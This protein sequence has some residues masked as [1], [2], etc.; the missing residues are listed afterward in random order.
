M[1]PGQALGR[2]VLSQTAVCHMAPL[3]SCLR[4]DFQLL[5]PATV[6]IAGP[7]VC[8]SNPSL[9]E[10]PGSFPNTPQALSAWSSH[11]TS[12]VR[13]V[14]LD[15]RHHHTHFHPGRA[16]PCVSLSVPTQGSPH[17]DHQH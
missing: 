8:T 9:L 1:T 13:E 12:P 3:S 16:V 7:K 4:R 17:T 11:T 5:Q 6:G 14:Q 2:C 10:K 15:L